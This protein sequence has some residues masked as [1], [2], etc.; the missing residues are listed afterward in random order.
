MLEPTAEHKEPTM[1]ACPISLLAAAG[2]L[3]AT[4]GLPARA[5]SSPDAAAIARQGNAHGA[6]PC[7]ACHGEHGGGNAVAGY[8]RLAGLNRAYLLKQL[9]DFASGKR[10]NGVMQPNA[11]GLTPAERKAMAAYYSAMPI[12]AAARQGAAHPPADNGPGARLALWGRWSRK[13]PACV[14][15]HG[16]HGVGVGA[17]FPP[18]AGQPATY[19]VRQLKAWRDGSRHNDPMQLMQHVAAGLSDKDIRAVAAWFAAQPADIEGG[20]R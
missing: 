9:D 14:R 2:L 7:Q 3:L 16:P 18:L 13:M 17:H 4:A 20:K 5:A 15:C 8:P 10:S 19:L 12:P 11:S 6:M 1:R